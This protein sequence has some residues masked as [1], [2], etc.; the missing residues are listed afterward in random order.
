MKP[1]YKLIRCHSG[2]DGECNWSECPQNRD[3]E[4]EKTGRHCPLDIDKPD[5][6]D[7]LIKR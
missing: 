7:E 6:Y 4:P 1:I 3:N 5:E 2:E